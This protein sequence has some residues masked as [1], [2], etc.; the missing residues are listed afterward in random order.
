MVGSFGGTSPIIVLE[1]PGL[2]DLEHECLTFAHP[3]VFSQD[4]ASRTFAFIRPVRVY[5]SESTEQRILG[6]LVYICSRGS[7]KIMD[8]GHQ[9]KKGI[10]FYQKLKCFIV[11]NM[12]DQAVSGFQGAIK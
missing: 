11:I 8:H 5:T 12:V 4:I 7:K 1:L 2:D 10:Y 6:T 9:P 3:P